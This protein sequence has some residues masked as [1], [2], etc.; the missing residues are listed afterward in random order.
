MAIGLLNS[1]AIRGGL[2][3]GN[4]TYAD[5]LTVLP[6]GNSVDLIQL[7]GKHLREALEQSVSHSSSLQ[8]SGIQMTVD[9]SRPKGQRITK[10]KVKCA[11]CSS[12]DYS[13][14]QDDLLYNI[15]LPNYLANGGGGSAD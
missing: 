4:I 14:L 10:V 13:D 5:M 15:T 3:I 6:F 1:G 2:L 7:S 12:D 9:L 11:K 8:V